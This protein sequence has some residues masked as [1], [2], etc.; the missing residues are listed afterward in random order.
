MDKVKCINGHFFNLDAFSCCPRCGGAMAG[1]TQDKG[2]G[3][4]VT[5]SRRSRLE[6]MDKTELLDPKDAPD[7]PP[8]T[9]KAGG[10]LWSFRKKEKKET[11][12]EPAPEQPRE[13]S[14]RVEIPEEQSVTVALTGE[15][16]V[17]VEIPAQQ[18][19]A[20]E[21]PAQQDVTVEL[22]VEQDPPQS[23]L[24]QAVIATGHDHTSAL[25]KTVAYYDFQETE[26]P[27][28]WL[29]CV[30]GTYRGQ[31]FACKTGRNKLGR[32]PQYE[33]SL[34]DDPSV[35]RK[36]HAFLI[37]EPKQRLFFLQNG[38]G[39]GLVYLNGSLLFS[40]EQLRAYDRIGIGNGEFLFLPLCGEQF[41]WD[42]Q[43]S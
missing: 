13:K 26:P 20:P 5:P 14:R 3:A 6:E 29:V 2:T 11:R 31:A 27:V 24:I 43:T 19:P 28:G 12:Q 25:P 36:P 33:I 15:Q 39:D 42:D 9:G 32:D 35:T 38:E 40:H 41:S 7:E 16:D 4:A 8:T 22:P 18:D 23:E 1:R 17:T 37:Y 34:M 21:R 10:I 30:Q